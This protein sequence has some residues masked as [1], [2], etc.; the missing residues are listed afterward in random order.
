MTLVANSP[1]DRT[2]PVKASLL[3]APVCEDNRDMSNGNLYPTAL[4]RWALLCSLTVI[5]AMMLAF[6]ASVMAQEDQE[7]VSRSNLGIARALEN[8]LVQVIERA[9][10]S[11]VAIA[12][13]QRGDAAKLQDPQFVPHEYCAGVIVDASGLILT[14]YHSLGKVADNDYVVWHGKRSYSDVKV[15]AADPWTDLAILEIKARELT[16]ISFGDAAE[17]KKG[18]IVISLGNPYAIA[19]D[20]N[21][22][23]TWGIVSKIGRKIDGPLQGSA[24]PDT[25][26]LRRRETLYH[27][28]GL[29]QTDAKLAKNTSGGPLLDLDGK[30][31][32]LSTSIA[33]LAG[34]EKGTGYA[35]PVDARFRAVLRKLKRG[36]EIE[37]GFLG[38]APRNPDPTQG[39]IGVILNRVELATPAAQGGLRAFDEVVR[40]D[41]AKIHTVDDLSFKIG[42]T[43]P[44]HTV[45]VTILQQRGLLPDREQTKAVRLSKRPR[46]PQ[47]DL[48]SRVLRSRV[49]EGCK[50]TTVQY[51]R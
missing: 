39:E 34:F 30:M 40:I 3:L 8:A 36:E 48:S 43:P 29:I 13:G 7:A 5:S 21:V 27:Y 31:I 10:L 24:G 35:I 2:L 19:R 17:I 32:G 16:P 25:V 50:W 37:N 22:S 51:W 18:R 28:G 14:N 9:E 46:I 38:V 49:G 1:R 42:S 26:D 4:P 20:G 6:P 33:I 23:A 11:V 12:R 45:N 47:P 44:G 15:K 41:E